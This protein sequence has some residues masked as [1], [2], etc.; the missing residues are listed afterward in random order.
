M[1]RSFAWLFSSVILLATSCNNSNKPGSGGDAVELRLNLEKGKTYGYAMKTDMNM[2]VQVLGKP[3]K[4]SVSMNFGFKINVD[5]IDSAHNYRVTSTYDAIKFK[6]SAMGMEMGYDSQ[7]PGD[8]TRADMFSGMFRKMFGG[9]LGKQFKFTL[10]PKGEVKDV[11]G[12]KEMVESMMNSI[13]IPEARKAAMQKQMESSFNEDQI[14]QGFEQGFS[15]FP[16]KPV[17]VGDSWDLYGKGD[18][19]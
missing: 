7:E 12:V 11:T 3:M 13:D 8:T 19:C 17:K 16:D 15:V 10:T 1:K 5:D 18:H 14:K 4:T 9:M 6:T 2:D